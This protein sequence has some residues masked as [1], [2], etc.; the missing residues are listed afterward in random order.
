MSHDLKISKVIIP[1]LPDINDRP[2]VKF[3]IKNSKFENQKTALESVTALIKYL[4]PTV[5]H[6]NSIKIE[7]ET[8]SIESSVSL[9]QIQFKK[10]EGKVFGFVDILFEDAIQG[11]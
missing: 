7:L 1:E 9:S 3:W 10:E 5:L 11:L 2:E 8:T 6:L 4:Y